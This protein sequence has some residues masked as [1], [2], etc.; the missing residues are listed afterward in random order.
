MYYLA[1]ML[2]FYYKTGLEVVMP[3]FIFLLTTCI[4]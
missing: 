1:K 3:Q 2:E 4:R